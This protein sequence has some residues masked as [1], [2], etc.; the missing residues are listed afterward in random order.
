MPII[1]LFGTSAPRIPLENREALAPVQQPAVGQESAG[2]QALPRH[3]V[4][5]GR[6]NLRRFITC[7]GSKEGSVSTAA[8]RDSLDAWVSKSPNST[9]EKARENARDRIIAWLDAGRVED[10]LDLS[11]E[12]PYEDDDTDE[13]KN[14]VPRLTKL[15][16]LPPGLQVLKVAGHKLKKLPTTL[17][18]SLLELDVSYNALESLSARLSASLVKLNVS[19]NNLKKFPTGLPA[20]LTELNISFNVL[21]KL[22]AD[23]L[24]A[25]LTELNVRSTHLESFP[26][27]LPA[28]LKKLIISLNNI[29]SL[30][31]SLH[32]SLTEL[33]AEE[34]QI[35]SLP[36]HLLDFLIRL[37]VSNCQITEIPASVLAAAA[38]REAPCEVDLRENPLSGNAR[39]QIEEHNRHVAM[40][41]EGRQI[42]PATN[43]YGVGR[44]W[45]TLEQAM[46]AWYDAP[47]PD[48]QAAWRNIHQEARDDAHANSAVAFWTLLDSLTVTKEYHAAEEGAPETSAAQ[49]VRAAFR[50]RVTTLLDAVQ[51]DKELRHICFGIALDSSENCQDRVALR[52]DQMEQA[53]LTL[54]ATRGEF[55]Q[56]DIFKLGLGTFKLN[57][58][59]ELAKRDAIAMKVPGEELEL[60]LYYRTKLADKLALP[61]PTKNMVN[62]QF[63]LDVAA[64]INKQSALDM[65][66]LVRKHMDV[67]TIGEEV[68]AVASDRKEIT[69]FLT[70]WEPWQKHLERLYP[71]AFDAKAVKEAKGKTYKKQKTLEKRHDLKDDVRVKKMN[72]LKEEFINMENTL[73]R[74]PWERLTEEF[75]EAN[76]DLWKPMDEC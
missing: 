59:N 44:R 62:E 23:L 66:P 22:P 25:S 74:D 41:N 37:N 15:P 76:T 70:T 45:N 2:A 34:M 27:K 35:E 49:T 8:Y 11:L 28:S 19:Y 10:P 7:F 50:K 68:Q 69:G 64:E 51:K 61:N 24:P 30:P 57:L 67:E 4:S 31:V 12:N 21:K 48:R 6:S 53:H 33:Q 54:R 75:L 26:D 42:L 29:Q 36:D 13:D 60:M 55:T 3:R 63:L 38:R 71:E 56:E 58:L 46:Q 9:E 14:R 39:R 52:F 40:N 5:S 72:E 1:N 43:A 73:F 47:D 32:A 18:P 17:L 20:S 65:A 16:P